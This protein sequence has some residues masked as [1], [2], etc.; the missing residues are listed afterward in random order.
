[1]NSLTLHWQNLNPL[2]ISAMPIEREELKQA[3]HI[4]LNDVIEQSFHF[5]VHQ[6]QQSDEVNLI[7]KD[8]G[9][10]LN[11]QLLK[12]DAHSFKTGSREL[13]EHYLAIN[14]DVHRKSLELLA[15]LQH[16]QKQFS[17]KNVRV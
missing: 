9:E 11:Y 3:V 15:R 5:L 17:D 14:R 13:D 8:A 4:M 10:E 1:M 2:I 16:L 6:P 12:V 7:I